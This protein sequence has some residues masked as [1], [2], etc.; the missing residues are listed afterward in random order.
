MSK[1]ESVEILYDARTDVDQ[2]AQRHAEGEVPDRYPYGLD[3]VA[4]YGVDVVARRSPDPL[5]GIPGRLERRLSHSWRHGSTFARGGPLLSWDE[6]AGIPAVLTTRRPVITGAIWVNDDPYRLAAFALPKAAAVWACS[7]AQLPA[8]RGI[9]VANPVYVP[10]GIDADFFTPQPQTT[11][12]SVLGVGND[13]HRDHAT[14]CAAVNRLAPSL[15]AHVELATRLDVGDPGRVDVIPHLS[16]ADLRDRY[17]AARVVALALHPN[18]HVSGV[19]ALLEAMACARPV[20]I[21]D[22]PGIREYIE[23]G[24]T[25]FLVPAGDVDAMTAAIEK[26]LRDPAMGDE[27]GLRA[28]KTVEARFTTEIQASA[29]AELIRTAS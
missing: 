4:N 26:L 14:F 10:M 13:K 9:G 11:G 5:E 17:R 16:H 27:M 1:A 29:L 23:D 6:R 12:A 24:V 18:V 22:N 21:T 19:T 2:W 20:V 28:R 25:G 15:G 3:R 7:T 8:L